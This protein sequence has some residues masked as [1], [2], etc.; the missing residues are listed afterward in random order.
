MEKKPGGSV[1]DAVDAVV[2]LLHVVD[3][4]LAL[5][6]LA[7]GA[8]HDGDRGIGEAVLMDLVVEPGMDGFEFAVFHLRIEIGDIAQDA[9]E[10]L[11]VED[12]AHGVGLELAEVLR[13]VDVLQAA[14]EVVGGTDA[15]CLLFIPSL[16]SCCP[17]PRCG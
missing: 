12:V 5:D 14:L 13:P 7:R 2:L 11:A 6:G 10:Q 16:L 3:V 9:L 15:L 17:E 8:L 1:L 4:V